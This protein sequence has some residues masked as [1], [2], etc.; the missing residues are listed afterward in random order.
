MWAQA[1]CLEVSKISKQTKTCCLETVAEE[2][3]CGD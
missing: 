1:A 3:I 2:G